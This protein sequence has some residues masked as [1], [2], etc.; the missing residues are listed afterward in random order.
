MT[1]VPI[2]MALRHALRP[3]A[4]FGYRVIRVIYNESRDPVHVVTAYFDRSMKGKL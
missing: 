3:I 1:S 2:F 4:E